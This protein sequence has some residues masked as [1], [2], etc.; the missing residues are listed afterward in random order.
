MIA[1]VL[2]IGV[3]LFTVPAFW[4]LTMTEQVVFRLTPVAIMVKR[5]LRLPRLAVLR[6][7]ALLFETEVTVEEE[8]ECTRTLAVNLIFDVGLGSTRS[9]T[10]T[11][12]PLES[13][14]T[15]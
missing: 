11:T 10:S 12:F 7:W 3:L 6:A 15:I 9:P 5:L 13:E 2:T 14:I 1:I 4:P 8:E